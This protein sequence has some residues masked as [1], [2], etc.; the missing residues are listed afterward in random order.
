MSEAAVAEKKRLHAK[1]KLEKKEALAQKKA[2]IA[3][4]RAQRRKEIARRKEER[5]LDELA[6]IFGR[7]AARELIK[8]EKSQITGSLL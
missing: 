3:Q 7:E 2:Q 4:K 6:K 1:K 8:A 5:K